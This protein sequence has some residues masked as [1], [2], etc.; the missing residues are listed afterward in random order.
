MRCLKQN[1]HRIVDGVLVLCL[2]MAGVLLASVAI[3][4][5][6]T[7]RRWTSVKSRITPKR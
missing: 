7:Q 6:T 1:K 2:S 3:V 4:T 5:E